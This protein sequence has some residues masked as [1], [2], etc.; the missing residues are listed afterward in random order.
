M[1]QKRYTRITDSER[2]TV[3][4]QQYPDDMSMRISS[5]SLYK[6]LYVKPSRELRELLRHGHLRREDVED[7]ARKR[8]EGR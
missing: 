6:Y 5:E 1:Q 2:D 3:S 4:W 8:H 7:R